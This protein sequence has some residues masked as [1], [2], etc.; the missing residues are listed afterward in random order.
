MPCRG[1]INLATRELWIQ[2][3][4]YRRLWV[5]GSNTNWGNFFY[6][7]VYYLYLVKVISTNV[8]FILKRLW[9]KL[10]VKRFLN[11]AK[12]YAKHF[13]LLTL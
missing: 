8:L 9:K 13:S 4:A 11:I 6:I 3:A 7:L 1:S 12:G 10:V 2:G 5:L